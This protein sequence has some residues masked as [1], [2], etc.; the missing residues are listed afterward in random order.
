MAYVAELLAQCTCSLPPCRWS[1]IPSWHG[2]SAHPPAVSFE[3]ARFLVPPTGEAGL[4][5]LLSAVA[6]CMPVYLAP[7]VV[8]LTLGPLYRGLG[9]RREPC[10][11]DPRGSLPCKRVLSCSANSRDCIQAVR[12]PSS[13]IKRST[14]SPALARQPRGWEGGQNNAHLV[15]SQESR[16]VPAPAAQASQGDVPFWSPSACTA[17]L[18]WM[19]MQPNSDKGCWLGGA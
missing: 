5:L 14:T 17:M 16:A 7:L 10:T 18:G 12:N 6:D 3:G 15:W 9:L 11:E 13:V 1:G 8:P 19:F 4:I 2:L